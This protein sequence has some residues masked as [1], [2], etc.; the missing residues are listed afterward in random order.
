MASFWSDYLKNKVLDHMRG[1]AAFT[2]GATSF[3]CMMTVRPTPVGGGTQVPGL[4]RLEISNASTSWNAAAAGLNSNKLEW[5]FTTNAPADLGVIV[6]I[7]EYD[8]GTG[9][10]LLTYG[11]LTTPKTVLTGMAFSVLAGAGQF[12]Y[13]D[14]LPVV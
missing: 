12:T 6:G 10:N 5:T 4:P 9:G 3:F 2:P 14:D 8:A 11:D 7:A 13:I 1:I